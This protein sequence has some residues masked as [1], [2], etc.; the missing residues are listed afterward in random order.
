MNFNEMGNDDVF[1]YVYPWSGEKELPS[2]E[3]LR[4]SVGRYLGREISDCTVCRNGEYGK[5][6]IEELPDVHFSISHS[7]GFWACAIGSAE[8]GLDLQEVKEVREEKLARRFF[9]PSEVEWLEEHGF[10][11]FSRLWAYKESYVKYTGVGLRDGM[12]YFSVV[13]GGLPACQQELPF[14]DGFYLVVTTEQKTPAQIIFEDNRLV[15][16]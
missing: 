7:G 10:D 3:L 12:D 4:Q 14:R 2:H 11:Q 15:R 1:V 16:L 6:Y 8:V 13:D 9:H 5:P